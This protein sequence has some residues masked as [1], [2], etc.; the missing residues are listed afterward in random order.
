MEVHVT[1]ALFLLCGL[2]FRVVPSRKCVAVAGIKSNIGPWMHQM[3]RITVLDRQ[4]G[5]RL[6]IFEHLP[7]QRRIVLNL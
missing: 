6:E 7:V 1:L 2:L 3:M 5:M 4:V